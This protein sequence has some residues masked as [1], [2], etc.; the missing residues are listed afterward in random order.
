MLT[1]LHHWLLLA[2]LVAPAPSPAT[3]TDAVTDQPRI[4][5]GDTIE[6]ASERIRLHGIDAPERKQTCEWPDKTIPCGRL[7][8]LALMDLTAGA[9]VTCKTLEKERYGRWVAR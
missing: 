4:I 1:R 8:L 3:A 2:A 5:D 6:V 9:V 7:A